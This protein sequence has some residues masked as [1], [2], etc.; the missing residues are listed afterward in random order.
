MATVIAIMHHKGN[1]PAVRLTAA[2]MLWE[3][4]YGRPIQ[5][6]AN[7]DL[8]F[9]NFAEISDEQLA[10][11]A[12]RVGGAIEVAK[13]AIADRDGLGDEMRIQ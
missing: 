4:G 10:R 11:L 5:P 12:D 6:V 2:A 13:A 1:P 9:I 3:R 8:S 7:P